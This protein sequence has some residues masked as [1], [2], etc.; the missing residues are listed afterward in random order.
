MKILISNDDSIHSQGIK[1]LFFFFK[2]NEILNFFTNDDKN[3]VEN[4]NWNFAGDVWMVAPEEEQSAQSHSFSLHRPIFIHNYA[5]QQMSLCGTPADCV[6]F[7]LTYLQKK[8]EPDE[9]S[10]TTSISEQSNCKKNSDFDWVVSGINHGSNLGSD[11]Y[12]SGTVAGAREACLRGYPSVA[13]SL[14][15]N[16]AESLQ[17]KDFDTVAFILKILLFHLPKPPYGTFYNINVPQKRQTPSSIRLTNIG[18]RLYRSQVIMQKSPSGQEFCWLGGPP[19]GYDGGIY[20]DDCDIALCD[21]G[22]I[23][24]SVIHL[25]GKE[26]ASE[27]LEEIQKVCGVTEHILSQFLEFS[28]I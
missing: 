20:G 4:M 28:S 25:F 7:A 18:L 8:T 12:Y 10:K 19:I 11:I 24:I 13:I 17:K 16:G 1:S 21:K 22:H 6:Y 27:L 26:C 2:N 15:P 23:T 5:E 14:H 3:H 9:N